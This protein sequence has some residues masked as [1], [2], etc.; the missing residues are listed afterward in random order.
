MHMLTIILQLI[1]VSA[2]IPSVKTLLKKLV[3]LL[4]DDVR[5]Y[6]SPRGQFMEKGNKL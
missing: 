4:Y 2:S 6:V 5:W 3:S 1:I